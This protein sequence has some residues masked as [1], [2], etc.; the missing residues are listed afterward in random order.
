M[1][2]SVSVLV[3]T[4]AEIA[5][6]V[7]VALSSDLAHSLVKFLNTSEKFLKYSP[8]MA[9]QAKLLA[10]EIEMLVIQRPKQAQ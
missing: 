4:P 10:V 9:S 6:S 5:P 1:S 2:A 8:A 7:A 3:S